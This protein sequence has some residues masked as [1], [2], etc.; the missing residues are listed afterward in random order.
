MESII[1]SMLQK[2]LGPF[3]LD[4]NAKLNTK[5]KFSLGKGQTMTL[6]DLKVDPQFLS[7]LMPG[8]PLKISQGTID[9]CVIRAKIH[10]L[11]SEPVVIEVGTVF[12]EITE[13]VEI[14]QYN[15]EEAADGKPHT[16]STEKSIPNSTSS[17][18]SSRE[19]D[20]QE[21]RQG[22]NGTTLKKRQ[23]KNYTAGAKIFHG[24]H[25]KIKEIKIQLSTLGDLKTEYSGH[26]LAG[27]PQVNIFVR[28]LDLWSVDQHGEHCAN[29]KKSRAFSKFLADEVYVFKKGKCA[30]SISLTPAN[31]WFPDVSV[32]E[33]CPLQLDITAVSEPIWSTMKGEE[34][35]VERACEIAITSQA[36]ICCHLDGEE[37]MMLRVVVTRSP[38]ICPIESRARQAI[39][40]NLDSIQR[41]SHLT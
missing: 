7:K 41:L 4:F 18:G 23:K 15:K 31:P 36:P 30:V 39:C 20:G 32:L 33:E 37:V 1:G 38:A 24:I 26:N 2:Y 35:Q 14:L 13:P 11:K 6:R 27:P 3:L 19:V 5:F 25:W 22:P 28:D 9:T 17:N 40:P 12:L 29:L 10:S 21:T 34:V 16:E 8:I